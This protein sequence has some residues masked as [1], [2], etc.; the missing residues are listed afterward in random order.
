MYLHGQ[1][2]I[3]DGRVLDFKEFHICKYLLARIFWVPSAAATKA[4]YDL[5]FRKALV[6]HITLRAVGDDQRSERL[7][8][9][10]PGPTGVAAGI[11]GITNGKTM[12]WNYHRYA[13]KHGLPTDKKRV[14]NLREVPIEK[15]RL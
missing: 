1:C 3:S 8:P 10:T 5:L 13:T 7:V 4:A 12:D 9:G 2:N 14:Q 15:I 11:A 6:F